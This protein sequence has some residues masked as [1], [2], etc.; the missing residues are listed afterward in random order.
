M[1]WKILVTARTL[2]V[3]GQQALAS[4]RSAA[5]AASVG[6]TAGA[7][8]QRL[9]Q[10]SAAGQR[11]MKREVILSRSWKTSE[12]RKAVTSE[13]TSLEVFC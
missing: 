4:L 1:A 2:D 8:C 12:L 3:V 11:W 9:C 10:A 13:E 5:E 7:W 6:A